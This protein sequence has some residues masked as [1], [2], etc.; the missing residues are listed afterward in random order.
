MDELALIGVSR[1]DLELASATL[2]AE[3]ALGLQEDWLP[4]EAPAPLQPWD[5]GPAPPEP[6]RV[7]LKAWFDAPDREAVAAAV[8]R[9][10]PELRW[11]EVEE[12]DWEAVS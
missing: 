5:R 4:G 8:A 9:F 12:Q 3:G 1:A 7:V 11:G 10:A 2:F 6:D